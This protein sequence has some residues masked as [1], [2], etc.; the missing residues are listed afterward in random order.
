MLELRFHVLVVDELICTNKLLWH[1]EEGAMDCSWGGWGRGQGTKSTLQR[2]TI[3]FF[4]LF[5][6]LHQVLVA[7]C[8]IFSY[9]MQTL[10]GS[11]LDLVP[12]P[13]MEPKP[14]ASGAQT[15]RHWTIREAPQSNRIWDGPCRMNRKWLQAAGEVNKVS[16]GNKL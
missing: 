10:I 14:A 13:G 15:V 12:W 1:S 6:W 16:R 11:M 2:N 8:K 5:I 4:K 9:G 3:F 7:A